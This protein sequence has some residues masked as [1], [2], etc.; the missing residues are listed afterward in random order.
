[1]HNPTTP[2]ATASTEHTVNTGPTHVTTVSIPDGKDEDF[3]TLGETA[4]I[5]RIPVSTLRWWRQRGDGP[6]F[7]KLGVTSSPPSVTSAPGS[8]SRSTAGRTPHEADRSPD[9]SSAAVRGAT[10]G[11]PRPAPNANHIAIHSLP[12]SSHL[13]DGSARMMQ[14]DRGGPT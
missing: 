10:T 8:R 7:F 9:H 14:S 6:R 12:Q 2:G 13:H 11:R 3:L 1:M 5:L 4:A